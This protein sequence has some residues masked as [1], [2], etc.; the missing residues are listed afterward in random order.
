MEKA[1]ESALL[2]TCFTELSSKEIEDAFD[3]AYTQF[4]FRPKY[5]LKRIKKQKTLSEIIRLISA[6]FYL[7]GFV[8]KKRLG[9]I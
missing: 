1:L 7:I 3:N 5:I 2:N 9:R 8:L 4:Y 6:G